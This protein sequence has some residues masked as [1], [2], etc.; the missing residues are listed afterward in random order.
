MGVGHGGADEAALTLPGLSMSRGAIIT[1]L[2][3]FGLMGPYVG[4]MKGAI[5]S[6]NPQA[7]VVDITHEV[8]PQ[9]VEEGAFILAQAWPYFPQGTVHVAVVDPGVGTG[10]RALA[11][12]TP[13]AVF[14]GPD[15]GLLSSALPE[16]WRPAAPGP[17]PLPPGV[18]AVA[19][20]N[21][22][23]HRHPVSPTF[24]GRDIFGPAAAHISRGVPL[25]ELGPPV[26]EVMA[27]PPFRAHRQPDGTL[28]GRIL[29]IDRFGNLVTTVRQEDLPWPKVK[30]QLGPHQVPGLVRT[31]AQAQGPCALIGSSGFL[32]I[33]VPGGSAAQVLGAHLGQAVRVEPA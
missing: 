7:L 31:Y 17:V 29:H 27:L 24:H 22:R 23:Y 4:A 20:E 6:V 32:E 16:E 21:P 28:E 25:E 11:L 5:L 12:A 14:V 30:V 15:N 3:D 10:R 13:H 8:H 9:Q 19:L 1:L 26:H 2:T 33:A 18:K